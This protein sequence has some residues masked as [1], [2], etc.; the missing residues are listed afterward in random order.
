M[1]FFDNPE[2]RILM[3]KLKVYLRFKD[4]I[5]LDLNDNEKSLMTNLKKD[6]IEL[7]ISKMKLHLLDVETGYLKGLS[8]LEQKYQEYEIQFQQ[9]KHEDKLENLKMI[10]LDKFSV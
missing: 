8:E 10:L 9:H 2:Y 1:N 4:K 6:E 3:E 7:L 5:Q